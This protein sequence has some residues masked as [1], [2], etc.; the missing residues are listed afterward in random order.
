MTETVVIAINGAE[1]TG[2]TALAQ[3]LSSR[4]AELTG[5]QCTWVPEQLRLWCDAQG[6]TP[7]ADEQ[8]AIALTQ[9]QT[10]DTAA[11][12]N[13]VVVC[14]TTPLM[15]AIYSRKLFNDNSIDAVALRVQRRVHITLLTALDIAWLADGLQRDGP[16]VREPVDTMLREFMQTHG[17][18][19]SVVTGHGAARL[20][21]ALAAVAP[22]FAARELSTPLGL[23]TRLDPTREASAPRPWSCEC[24]DGDCEHRSLGNLFA[25]RA[26][27]KA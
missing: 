24:V 16:Q 14:D 26:K 20:D 10:I 7:R 12:T 11:L 6:R 21:K 5:Q 17:L 4:L 2:K 18:G 13:D 8:M 27:V 15:T 25:A 19:W 22:L 23:F 9:E 1:C 3:A